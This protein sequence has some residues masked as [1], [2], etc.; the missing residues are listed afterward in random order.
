MNQELSIF[1]LKAFKR[2][3]LQH[4][5]CDFIVVP[6][7]VQPEILAAVNRDY[8]EIDVAGNFKPE[9]LSYGRTFATM[10]EELN[11][12]LLK[13]KF[14]EKFG[15]D[16]DLYPLQITVRKYS[17]LSDGNVHNDSKGKML[18]SLIYFNDEWKHKNGRLR[19]L[20]SSWDIENY[21]AE[22][23]PARGTLI[24]FRRSEKSFHGFKKME[25][26]RR[27]L[28]MYWVKPKRARKDD[29]LPPSFKKRIKRLL[30][31]RPRWLTAKSG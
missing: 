22:V 31:L 14:A 29:S 1:D 18:T 17:E 23:E 15:M 16:L 7:F 9:D 27:S 13:Q 11:S 4:D 28:Q 24:S 25:G 3:E 26:E 5:P 10:L 2:A 19:L 20:R 6:E 8:P 21:I 30:K 12:P